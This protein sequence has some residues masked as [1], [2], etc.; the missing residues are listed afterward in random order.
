MVPSCLVLSDWPVENKAR[1][2]GKKLCSRMQ[3]IVF[4][5]V[6]VGSLCFVLCFLCAL[7]CGRDW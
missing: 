6:V 7:F 3:N 2:G 1:L 4:F 5:V